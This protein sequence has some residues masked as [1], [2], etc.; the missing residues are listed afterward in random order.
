MFQ[1]TNHLQ[2]ANLKI[3]ID[4]VDVPIQTGDIPELCKRLPEGKT[5]E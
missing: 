1:N 5:W 3:A 4:V 2:F